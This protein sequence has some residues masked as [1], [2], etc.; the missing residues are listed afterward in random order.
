MCLCGELDRILGRSLR[1]LLFARE[2]SGDAGVLDCT[3][4]T[5]PALFALEVALYRLVSSFGLKADFLI[6]HS[7]GELAAAFV[8][9]VFGLEDACRLVAGRGRLMGALDGAGA[10]AAVMASEGEVVESLVGFGDR[11]ALAAVNGPDAVVVS[12]DEVALGEWEAEYGAASN[13]GGE[14]KITRL[15][16]SNAFHSVLMDP[17]LDEFREL[18]EGVEFS[19]PEIPIV[20][21][22]TGA[23]ADGGVLSDPEYWVSQVRGTVRF[24]DG[25][26]CLHGAGVTR[27]LELGPDGVL[28]GMT[29]ECLG[30][31]SS[32]GEDGGSVST[33]VV[34]SALRK[35][36]LEDRAFLG[37][38]A[39]A[40]VNGLDVDWGS[41]FDEQRA[42]S[43]RLPTYAFQRRHYWL[44]PGRGGTDAST[45][46][47]SPAEHPLLGAALHLA[48]EDD[49]WLFTGRLSIETHPW[50]KDH[51]VMG[52]ILMP[53]TGLIELALAAGQHI[54]ADVVE[55][56]TLTSPLLI[57]E[58]GATHVQV[59]LSGLRCRRGQ[60]GRDLLAC[61][62]GERRSRSR[63]RTGRCTP[64]VCCGRQT[65]V[66]PPRYPA[67]GLGGEWPPAGAQARR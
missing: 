1:D 4:F 61:A 31:S 51:A 52:A 24:A 54:G 36:R 66:A 6:G 26:R 7:I 28:S 47:Q 50:L 39:R 23:L 38:L 48:G 13:G 35:Q 60:E 12:G 21:N 11:L 64:R 67:H 53:G 10:M 3:E 59:T 56:L 33:V 30:G 34:A 45:L 40:H 29:H 22:V 65:P 41:F 44:A 63:A 14:R 58:D 62:P 8:A 9:G 37:F 5:Q 19:E 18:A 16:V 17:M 2:G 25:V 57:P 43:V 32:R 55:E 27:F 42:K 49:A 20:S 15:R 46:G